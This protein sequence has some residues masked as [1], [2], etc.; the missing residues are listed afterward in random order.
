MLEANFQYPSAVHYSLSAKEIIQKSLSTL[1]T[2]RKEALS[3]AFE[4]TNLVASLVV[5]GFLIF[6]SQKISN[7]LPYV[8][9]GIIIILGQY[10]IKVIKNLKKGFDEKRHVKR[11]KKRITTHFRIIYGNIEPL[12]EA[13]KTIQ[14]RY[15]E[16]DRHYTPTKEKK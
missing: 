6:I 16:I 14:N 3:D 9:I 7:I 4:I 11:E 2:R 5:S 15:E 13:L 1:E 10:V 12:V 8:S